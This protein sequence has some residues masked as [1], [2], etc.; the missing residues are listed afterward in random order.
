MEHYKTVHGPNVPSSFLEEARTLSRKIHEDESKTY[1]E[2]IYEKHVMEVRLKKK[3]INVVS[4][5]NELVE[6]IFANL[7]LFQHSD[8]PLDLHE[9]VCNSPA[10]KFAAGSLCKD[11]DGSC[12][13]DWVLPATVTVCCSL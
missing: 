3:R 13:A 10:A 2:H 11:T 12:Q 1:L 6:S 5:C 7:Y 8:D 9:N 4:N